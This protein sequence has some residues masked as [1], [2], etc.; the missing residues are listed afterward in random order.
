[1]S[2]F[3]VPCWDVSSMRDDFGMKSLEVMHES[4]IRLYDDMNIPS[5]GSSL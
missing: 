5:A 1:M 4:G 3:L 2:F